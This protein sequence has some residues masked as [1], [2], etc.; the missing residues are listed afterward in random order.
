MQLQTM[1]VVELDNG[2]DK[3]FASKPAPVCLCPAYETFRPDT[4]E[5]GT[6]NLGSHVKSCSILRSVTDSVR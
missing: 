4:S 6:P 2:L 5:G 3:T 1:L